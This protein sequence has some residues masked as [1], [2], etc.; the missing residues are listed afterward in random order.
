M[1][2][3]STPTSLRSTHR[4]ATWGRRTCLFNRSTL[5]SP[6]HSTPLP[7]HSD[8]LTEEPKGVGGHVCLIDPLSSLHATPLHSHFTPIHS[9]KS[10]RGGHV[11]LIDPLSSLHATPLH[12]HFTPIHSQKSQRGRRT[13]WQSRWHSVFDP[14]EIP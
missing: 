4:R 5:Q 12:S 13:F 14:L 9:Q 3:H 7:L 6:C 8:P 2:L 10:P 11:C 1:P